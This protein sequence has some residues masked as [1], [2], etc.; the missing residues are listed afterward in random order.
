MQARP[1]D[2]KK[3]AD[4]G[5]D[6]RI[7][8][9]DE[10]AGGKTKQIVLSV[11]AG[12]TGVSHVR[13]LRGVIEREGAEIGVL[14]SMKEPTK[15]MR[16]EAAGAEFYSSPGWNTKHPRLQILT[17]GQ[18]LEGKQIDYP[19]VTGVTFKKAPKAEQDAPEMEPL[20]G[21]DG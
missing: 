13:D 10:S 11:K 17:V 4:H 7:Y 14:I 1:A 16:A 12:G 9:H 15:P 18:L 5:I 3:G 19:H 2:Q 21:L 20:P 6:G 8:F